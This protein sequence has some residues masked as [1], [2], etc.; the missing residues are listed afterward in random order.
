[1]RLH[2]RR[3]VCLS[4]KKVARY[5]LCSRTHRVEREVHAPQSENERYGIFRIPDTG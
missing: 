1:M 2:L 4:N 3:Y 5:A